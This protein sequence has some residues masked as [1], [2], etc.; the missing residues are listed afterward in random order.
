MDSP[1]RYV[2]EAPRSS[3]LV[4]WLGFNGVRP[5]DVPYPAR[6]FVE[7]ADGAAWFIR[8]DAYARSAAGNI[9]YDI[10]TDTFQHVERSVPMAYDPPMWWLRDAAP[11]GGEGAASVL[12]GDVENVSERAF[13][14]D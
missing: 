3:E 11:A 8:Y 13:N 10:A 5:H 2:V 14:C 6:I 12:A 9:I 4:T 1:V 7:T